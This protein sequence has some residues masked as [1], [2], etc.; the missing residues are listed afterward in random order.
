[1]LTTYLPTETRLM[2]KMALAKASGSKSPPRMSI[3]RPEK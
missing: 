1:M 2:K 3:T